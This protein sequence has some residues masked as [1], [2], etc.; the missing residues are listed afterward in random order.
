MC[1][2]CL[3]SFGNMKPAWTLI[4][5]E[6]MY[7]T[8]QR[9]KKTLHCCSYF[10]CKH[11][12]QASLEYKSHHHLPNSNKSHCISW[13]GLKQHGYSLIDDDKIFQIKQSISK[14]KIR[15]TEKTEFTRIPSPSILF[16]T[17]LFVCSFY[18]Y[19]LQ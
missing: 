10:H 8:K 7:I 1:M 2:Q 12:S 16:H 5:I 3:I 13:L 19:N 9:W 17:S 4:S 11:I 14:G 6:Y 18:K 15:S